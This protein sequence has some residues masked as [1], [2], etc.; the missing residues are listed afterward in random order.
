M[1]FF[2][3]Y[4]EVTGADADLLDAGPLDEVARG[5]EQAGFAGISLTEH[6]APGARWLASGG[7]QTLDPFVGLGFVA[8]A[9]TRLRLLTHLSVATYRNPFL[10]A[11]AAATVDKLSGGRMVF[12]I[13]V[14]YL[15]TEFFALGVDFEERNALFDEVLEVLPLHWSGEPFSYQGRHFSARDV[16]ARPRPVQ[17]P[18]PV[19]IGGNARISRQRAARHGQ[20]WMPMPGGP[21]LSTTART[22]QIPDLT[23]LATMIAEV[24]RD[25][26]EAGRPPVEIQWTYLDRSIQ[27]PTVEADRHREVFAELGRIGVT[28]I[29]V[30]SKTTEATATLD[31]IGT[32][33][34]TYLS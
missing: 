12:G 8:A 18:I 22:V 9:T 32:F 10:L 25:A 21:E 15:K 31:F 34:E 11:K 3:S 13:G 23:T 4:P 29:V 20:G 17:D 28:S 2:F 1:Q 30:S 6:P 33:G 14:G 7:H 27:Q 16:I 26:E 19:W 24:Q 5:A